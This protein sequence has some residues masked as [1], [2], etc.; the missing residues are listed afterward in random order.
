[1]GYQMPWDRVGSTILHSMY[2]TSLSCTI[3]TTLSMTV[4]RYQAICTP[5]QYRARLARYG[6]TQLFLVYSMPAMLMATVLNIPQVW[7][8]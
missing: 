8:G 3:F 4:E 5:T 2:H 7:V 6:H 1:M